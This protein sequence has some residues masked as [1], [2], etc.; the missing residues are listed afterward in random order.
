MKLTSLRTMQVLKTCLAVAMSGILLGAV[1]S[2]AKA[3]DPAPSEL[4]KAGQGLLETSAGI[5]E[6]TPKTCA[7]YEEDGVFDIEIQGPGTA[8]DGEVFYFD[9]SSTANEMGLALGVDARFKSSDRKIQAGQFVS[10]LFE[11]EVSQKVISVRDLTLVD[12][13]GH[14]VDS[15]AALRIN[16][17]TEGT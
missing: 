12:E 4:V 9:F 3:S 14:L 11:V 15:N 17:N 5:Y 7:I 10:K 13:Q 6:F 1:P 8:P 16:C 2:I